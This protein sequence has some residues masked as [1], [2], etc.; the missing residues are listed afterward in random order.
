VLGHTTWENALG[1]EANDGYVVI[2]GLKP[3]LGYEFAIQQH[4]NCG[5]GPLVVVVDGPVSSLFT[6]WYIQ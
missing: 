6:E 1:D 2:G 4:V 5:G 3:D